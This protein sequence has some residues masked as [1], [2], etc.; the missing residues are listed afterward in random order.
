M[1]LKIDKLFSVAGKTVLVTGGGRGIG[2]MIAEGFVTNGADVFISARTK[3][4]VEETARELTAAGPGKC[5]GIVAD[6]T[7]VKA[8]EELAKRLETEFG[9]KQLHVLVNNSGISWGAPLEQFPEVGWDRV[10]DLNVKT[11][12]FLTKALLPLLRAA[13]SHEDP[14]RV[15]NVGSIAGFRPGHLPTYSYAASKAA[16]HHLSLKLAADLAT[17][18][19]TVNVL[20]PGPVLE[21]SKMGKSMLAYGTEDAM[22]KGVPLDKLG[23]AEDM[24]GLVL[25]LCSRGGAWITGAVVPVDG[26]VLVATPRAPAAAKPKAKL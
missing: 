13:G 17:S 2:R 4:E 12:F 24:A 1:S 20:A 11:V 7:A 22:R 19:I 6:L 15:V 21:G 10:M 5:F 23:Q 9:V 25:F 26:G 8:C 3:K 18:H 16:V 14:A